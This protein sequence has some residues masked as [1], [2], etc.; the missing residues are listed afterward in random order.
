MAINPSRRSMVRSVAWSA[1]AVALG[2]SAPALAAST[3]VPLVHLTKAELEPQGSYEVGQAITYG[4]VVTNTG[5]VPLANIT[6]DDP[7]LGGRLDIDPP[8]LDPGEVGSTTAE[9]VLTQADID[10]GSIVNRATA[11]GTSPLG[12]EVSATDEVTITFSPAPAITLEKRADVLAMPGSGQTIAYTLIVGNSGNIPL[13]STTLTDAMLGLI[14]E[15]ASAIL[16]PGETASWTGTYLVTDDDASAGQV[17]N[18]ASVSAYP[19]GSGPAVEAQA[20]LLLTRAP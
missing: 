20:D 15:E 3:G 10:R 14:D 19:P 1:P 5:E 9:L 6:V 13:A 18:T 17:Y 11:T 12:V 16:E 4:F 7:L 8:A 2:A